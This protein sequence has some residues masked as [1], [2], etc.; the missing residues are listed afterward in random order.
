MYDFCLTLPYAALLAL[1]GLMG[2]LT[3]GSVPS[4][5]GGLGSAAVLATCGQA[6]LSRYHQGA[7]CRPATAASLAVAAALTVVMFRRWQATGK[8]M[9][10]GL[11]AVLSGAMVIFYVWNMIFVGPPQRPASRSY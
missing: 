8:F 1:G 2:F 10:A 6:S 5:L 7:L 4:L 11:V 3:K 9:P